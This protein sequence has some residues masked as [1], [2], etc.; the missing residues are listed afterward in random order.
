MFWLLV[1]GKDSG[2]AV[3]LGTYDSYPNTLSVIIDSVKSYDRGVANEIELL[4]QGGNWYDMGQHGAL[5]DRHYGTR[6]SGLQIIERIVRQS[7]PDP[8]YLRIQ[9]ES[10]QEESTMIQTGAGQTLM[11][12]LNAH[13]FSYEQRLQRSD[14][15]NIAPGAPQAVLAQELSYMHRLR[16][17][18]LNGQSSRPQSIAVERAARWLCVIL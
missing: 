14:A 8:G 16:M 6:A 4:S 11:R 17:E 2:Y 12:V 15:E 3:S 9:E 18:M 13:I 1:D 7:R 5:N 10:T